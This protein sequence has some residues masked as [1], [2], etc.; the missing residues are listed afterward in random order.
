MQKKERER[1]IM[2]HKAPS[3]SSPN[4]VYETLSSETKGLVEH[5]LKYLFWL[6]TQGKHCIL[7]VS[8]NAIKRLHAA[9][10]YPIA[11]FIR[12]KSVES[13]M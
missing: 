5:D 7:D 9:Q 13:I 11:I 8:G 3:Y 2:G 10:L 4:P 6:K 12:P 1:N